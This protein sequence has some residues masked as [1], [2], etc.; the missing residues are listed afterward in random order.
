MKFLQWVETN[1]LNKLSVGEARREM[2][3]RPHGL[4]GNQQY[5]S[6]AIDTMAFRCR[7]ADN[8]N[9]SSMTITFYYY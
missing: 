5:L 7:T 8:K 3:L 2:V 9:S 6:A 1:T 4:L